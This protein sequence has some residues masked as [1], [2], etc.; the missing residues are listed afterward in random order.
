MKVEREGVIIGGN[1]VRWYGGFDSYM[2]WL[3]DS[4]NKPISSSYLWGGNKKEK[5]MIPD[6]I[7]LT[8]YEHGQNGYTALSEV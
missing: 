6:T 1:F 4:L 2:V 7:I 5:N 8:L 3:A